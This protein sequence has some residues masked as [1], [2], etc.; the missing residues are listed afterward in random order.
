MA[1]RDTYKYQLKKGGK[2]VHRGITNDLDRRQ[3]E[4]QDEYPNSRIKQV[5][6]QTTREAALK[7]EREGG[8]RRYRNS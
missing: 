6:R 1:E 5:G 2:I 8:K 7:W 3:Q 4:H